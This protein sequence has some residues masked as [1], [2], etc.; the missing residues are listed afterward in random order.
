[1]GRAK[2]WLP[3]RGQPMVAHVV[4]IVR[5][6]VDEVVVVASE[7]LELPP[8]DARVVRDREPELGP[9]AGIREGLEC[10]QAEF[11]F[12]TGTDAPFLTAAFVTSLLSHRCAAAPE[13]D[14]HVQT[15]AAVYLRSGLAEAEA[16]LATRRARPLY[17]LEALDYRKV[18]ADGLP[19]VDSVRG[20]NTPGEYLDALREQ[21]RGAT[22]TLELR[23]SLR[24]A[25]GCCEI[26][27]PVGT[28]AEVLAPVHSSIGILDG[29]A[30]AREFS[31]S[32][33][34]C[35]RIQSTGIPVGAGERVVID[36][37]V[38]V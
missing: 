11:A 30:I 21:E 32:M 12:V 14:G 1:M 13:I 16:I 20:F 10:I 24:A 26:E 6:V 25:M 28:L 37:S 15:L 31:V 3:W 29:D 7:N 38:G 19:D 23:G 8:L 22:A 34:G 27:V 9:L 2:A 4:S 17:L 33:T 18:G 36:A 5:P 35:D